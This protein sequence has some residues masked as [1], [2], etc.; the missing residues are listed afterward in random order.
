MTFTSQ[1]RP[2]TLAH[3]STISRN[4][5]PGLGEHKVRDYLEKLDAFKSLGLGTPKGAVSKIYEKSLQLK[6]VLDKW[7][8]L[9]VCSFIRRAR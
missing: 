8:R 7:K 1:G 5:Q 9:V 3:N 2:Q 6:D 4:G